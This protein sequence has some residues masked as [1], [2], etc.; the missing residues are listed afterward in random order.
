MF[1]ARNTFLFTLPALLT[2]AAGSALNAQTVAGTGAPV[3][4]NS[5]SPVAINA[6]GSVVV[7][8]D[9]IGRAF[10][11]THDETGGTFLPMG[12]PAGWALTAASAATVTEEEMAPT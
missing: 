10:V 1:T 6:D 2:L 7:G 4:G 8:N 5:F 12:I 3:D 9:G 11:W